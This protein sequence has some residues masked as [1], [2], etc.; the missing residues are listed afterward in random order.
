MVSHTPGNINETTKAKIAE[1]VTSIF[2]GQVKRLVYGC[3]ITCSWFASS[4]SEVSAQ[5]KNNVL[6]VVYVSRDEQFFSLATQHEKEL[7]ETCDEVKGCNRYR[8][9][10][11][12]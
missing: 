8:P 4:Q 7:C 1:K 11:L 5:A 9:L 12:G 6:Y 2:G 3:V 10:V